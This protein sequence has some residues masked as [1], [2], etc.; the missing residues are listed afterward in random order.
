MLQPNDLHFNVM[1]N[2]SLIGQHRICFRAEPNLL[3]AG[4]SLEI[5]VR[6][7]PVPFFRY[8]HKV[9]ETWRE[10]DFLTFESETDENG[11]RYRVSATR[12]AENVIV[13]SSTAGRTIL[14]AQTIPLTHWNLLCVERPLFNPQDGTSMSPRIEV[15]GDEMVL[16]ADGCKVR[17]TRYSLLIKPVLDN[18]YD[19]KRQWTAFAPGVSTAPP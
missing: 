1:R 16:L 5:V 12:T 10:K 9:N 2:G 3:I 15:G 17:A 6:L 11:R 7:G 4:I 8:S 14:G 19:G 18:W 13:E